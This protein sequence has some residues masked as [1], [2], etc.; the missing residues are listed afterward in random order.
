MPIPGARMTV[1]RL[2]DPIL[3]GNWGRI[4]LSGLDNLQKVVIRLAHYNDPIS[5]WEMIQSLPLNKITLLL[6]VHPNFLDPKQSEKYSQ[7]WKDLD[8]VLAPYVIIGRS[9]EKP[10][11]FYVVSKSGYKAAH[12]DCH[13]ILPEFLAR[14]DVRVDPKLLDDSHYLDTFDQRLTD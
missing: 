6:V 10:L 4:D 13:K 12:M 5:A 9:G 14:N 2:I 8:A 3:L 1:W 11:R 7:R